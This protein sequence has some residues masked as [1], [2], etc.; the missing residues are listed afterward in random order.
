MDHLRVRKSK[1]S[2]CCRGAV[3]GQKVGYHQ[4]RWDIVTAASTT[5][6]KPTTDATRPAL[7]HLARP[8]TCLPQPC[9]PPATRMEMP[10]SG[11]EELPTKLH[12]S[13]TNAPRRIRR[14]PRRC[15][16]PTSSL[17]EVCDS[18]P[19]TI[20]SYLH[21]RSCRR[22][23]PNLPR[24]SWHGQDDSKRARRDHHYKRRK[25]HA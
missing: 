21:S 4:G 3:V 1:I 12:S 7:R 22:C 23:C 25:H 11:Y 8:P 2:K 17:P 10:L 5:A 9:P 24:P 14:S 18:I 6:T 19:A 16:L 15:A 20:N 13:P